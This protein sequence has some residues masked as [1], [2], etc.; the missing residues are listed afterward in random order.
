MSRSVAWFVIICASIAAVIALCVPEA[1]RHFFENRDAIAS[2]GLVASA[3]VSWYFAR[4]RAPATPEMKRKQ[5]RRTLK[6]GGIIL[7]ACLAIV[8][9]FKV[10]NAFTS[11]KADDA[12]ITNV[13]VAPP[14]CVNAAGGAVDRAV[15]DKLSQMLI[16]IVHQS[17]NPCFRISS[18]W[19]D[20]QSRLTRFMCFDIN[21]NYYDWGFDAGENR[22]SQPMQIISDVWW[23]EY[24]ARARE[25]DQYKR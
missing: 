18:V 1:R 17:G 16:G 15:C 12:K 20:T 19:L 14:T 22:K 21:N 6:V 8:L 7:V 23:Q 4:G 11:H 5:T 3:L 10:L 13:A 2:V 24:L 25:R 9:G